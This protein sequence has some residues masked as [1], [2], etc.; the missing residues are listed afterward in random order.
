MPRGVVDRLML[1]DQCPKNILPIS[2][3]GLSGKK[4]KIKIKVAVFGDQ[5]LRFG[6]ARS[7]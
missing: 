6:L 1:L 3:F 4:D 5:L 7:V 2:G